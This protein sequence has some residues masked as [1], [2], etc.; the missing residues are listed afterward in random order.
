MKF[1]FGLSLV[2]LKCFE[3]YS[4]SIRN[5]TVSAKLELGYANSSLPLTES[6]PSYFAFSKL[7]LGP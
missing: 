5:F 3:T 6:K 7:E 1:I 2:K 4:I